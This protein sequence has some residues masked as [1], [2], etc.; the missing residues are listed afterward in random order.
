MHAII[1]I[2]I[3]CNKKLISCPF[4][5]FNIDCNITNYSAKKAQLWRL[6]SA[7]R[8]FKASTG[9]DWGMKLNLTESAGII[10]TV[11]QDN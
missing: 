11:T 2:F 6:L 3:S 9:T 7:F 8:N 4:E 10:K 1:S 5:D